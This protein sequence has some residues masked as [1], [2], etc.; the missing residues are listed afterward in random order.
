MSLAVHGLQ[1]INEFQKERVLAILNQHPELSYHAYIKN[2]TTNPDASNPLPRPGVYFADG[3]PIKKEHGLTKEQLNYIKIMAVLEWNIMLVS[4]KSIH[5][6]RKKAMEK[7]KKEKKKDK[8]ENEKYIAEMEAKYK[9]QNKKRTGKHSEYK[10]VRLLDQSY[11][12]LSHTSKFLDEL[13]LRF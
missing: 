10:S 8:Q 11:T 4:Q 5:K 9:A 12:W 6:S 7:I 1:G 2:F 13:K 3:V